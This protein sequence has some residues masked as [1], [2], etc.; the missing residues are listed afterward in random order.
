MNATSQ[1]T[2]KS[3]KSCQN[4][5]TKNSEA[6]DLVDIVMTIV[7]AASTPVAELSGSLKSM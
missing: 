7:V 5:T 4:K 1:Y 3:A 6:T 2:S